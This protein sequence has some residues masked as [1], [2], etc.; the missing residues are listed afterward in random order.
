MISRMLSPGSRRS[1]K[2]T[3]EVVLANAATAAVETLESRELLSMTMVDGWTRVTAPAGAKTIYVSSSSGNDGNSG[4]SAS[5]PVRSLSRAQR[6]MRSGAGDQM[7]LKRGDTFREAFGFWSISGKDANNPALIGTYGSGARPVVSS[8]REDALFMSWN[9][10]SNLAVIGIHFSAAGRGSAMPD[11][12]TSTGKSH[13]ILV[14][15]CKVDGYRNNLE[16]QDHEGAVSNIRIRRSAI[17]NSYSPNSHAQGLFADGVRGITLEENVFDHNGW[18]NGGKMTMFNHGAYVTGRSSGL[19]ARGNVFSNNSAHG[20]QARPGG[21]I[22]S[23]LFLNNATHLSFGVVNGDGWVTPGGVTGSVTNNVFTG[24][25]TIGGVP[26]GTGVELANVKSATV[27]DN[28]FLNGDTKAYNPAILLTDVRNNKNPGQATGINNLTVSNNVVYGWAQGLRVSGGMAVKNLQVRGNDFQNI[29]YFQAVQFA[30]EV[31]G[32]WSGN[33]YHVPNNSKTPILLRSRSYTIAGWRK[34]DAG[35]QEIRVSY[36]DAGRSV[37][38]YAANF[39]DRA[40]EQTS[41]NWD[42]RYTASALVS[43]MRGGFRGGNTS[44]VPVLGSS[45]SPLPSPTP[46]PPAS[47]G[48]VGVS[49]NDVRVIEGH[50]GTRPA[51]FT[52]RLASKSSK[53]VS[54]RWETK[55]VTAKVGKDY[56]GRNGV[57]RFAAG[58][59]TKTVTIQ[60]RGDRTAGANETF[61]LNLLS[62]DNGTITDRQG[63]CTIVD[64]D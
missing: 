39:I 24:G 5:S 30:G 46:P 45:P 19:T 38:R 3:R 6:L 34:Y 57:V 8:G 10:V 61:A 17:V 9:G 33:R 11:G 21:T 2:A 42:A 29:R 1:R 22:N 36:P 16:F 23:N 7:L 62:A 49:V 25:H 59:T 32:S 54:V 12:I 56:I 47:T 13:N 35:A 53:V 28:L 58:E 52:I 43:Y 18:G 26:F 63:I 51:T 4:T 15:D 40:E 20:L 44:S 37:T 27:A 60:V 64:D 14:E 50:T 48:G 31:I 55:G 41:G